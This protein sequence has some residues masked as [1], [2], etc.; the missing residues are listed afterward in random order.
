MASA[1][2]KNLFFALL[3]LTAVLLSIKVPTVW[4][5]AAFLALAGVLFLAGYAVVAGI[6]PAPAED[7]ALDGARRLTISTG[8]GLGL[9][10]L[11]WTLSGYLTQGL[12]YGSV[13]ILGAAALGAFRCRAYPPRIGGFFRS[14]SVLLL[15]TI[16][17]VSGLYLY[18]INEITLKD[19]TLFTFRMDWWAHLSIAGL[20]G[21]SGLPLVSSHGSPDVPFQNATHLGY[22][23]LIAGIANLTRLPLF[24]VARIVL[25]LCYWMIPIAAWCLVRRLDLGKKGAVIAALSGLL[26]CGLSLPYAVATLD[27]MAI[28]DPYTHAQFKMNSP[29][30]SMYHNGTQ[31]VSV[32]FTVIA[33]V[34]MDTLQRPRRLATWVLTAALLMVASLTKPSVFVA[35]VP[36]LLMGILLLR[37]PRTAMW[38]VPAVIAV[39]AF[40]YL[41]PSILHEVPGALSLRFDL[42]NIANPLQL[43]Q[44][45]NM[46]G[47]GLAPLVYWLAVRSKA[48]V[49]SR[50]VEWYDVATLALLGGLAFALFFSEPKRP[51]HGNQN[52]AALGAAVVAAPYLVALLITGYRRLPA[53]GAWGRPLRVLMVLLLL[54]QALHAVIYLIAYPHLYPGT[55]DPRKIEIV[56]RAKAATAPGDR[57]LIDPTLEDRLLIPYLNRPYLHDYAVFPLAVRREDHQWRAIL[58]GRSKRFIDPMLRSRDAVVIGPKTRFLIKYLKKMKWEK[59]NIDSSDRFALWHAPKHDKTD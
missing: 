31:L 18:G 19:Q 57:V 10:M 24:Q 11:L 48:V 7:A 4:T 12:A 17:L 14:K 15:S 41:L 34:V 2:T 52:W 5:G 25:I 21:E 33:M 53:Q 9:A 56:K 35:F 13:A 49:R 44:L 50:K 32:A 29:S 39:G 3:A 26:W 8:V 30:G 1:V 51:G 37:R 28:I 16:A 54:M 46:M 22:Q 36:A 55:A 43:P 59:R 58:D 20:V 47:V 27:W 42:S 23:V 6:G 45:L 40:V 38:M